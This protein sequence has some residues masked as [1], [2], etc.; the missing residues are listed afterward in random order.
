MKGISTRTKTIISAIFL[1]TI[2]VYGFY[3]GRIHNAELFKFGRYTVGTTIRITLGRFGR[4]VV[5][6]YTVDGKTYRMVDTYSYDAKVPGGRYL[7]KFSS[8]DP[9]IHEIQLNKEIPDELQAPGKG[10]TRK[11]LTGK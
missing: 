7:V 8:K 3:L 6:E 9:E 10:W 5:Y 2:L 11:E 1:V 4:N